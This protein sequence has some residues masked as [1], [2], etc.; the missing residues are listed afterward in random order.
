MCCARSAVASPT[1]DSSS[2]RLNYYKDII[3]FTLLGTLCGGAPSHIMHLP[4]SRV[5]VTKMAAAQSKSVEDSGPGEEYEE[6]VVLHTESPGEV[7]VRRRTEAWAH[8]EQELRNLP[9]RLSIGQLHSLPGPGDRLL[10]RY[11]GFLCRAE[12]LLLESDQ[13]LLVKLLDHGVIKKVAQHQLGPLKE[14]RVRL[15][16]PFSFPV[17]LAGVE[18]A[19]TSGSW[20]CAA[21][22]CLR[23]LFSNNIVEMEL[24]GREVDLWVGEMSKDDPLG[25]DEMIWTSAAKHVM[26]LGV[27]LPLGTRQELKELFSSDAW[28]LDDKEHDTDNEN[29]MATDRKHEIKQDPK[30][31][32]V[33]ARSLVQVA[34]MI[35]ACGN[36]KLVD[37]DQKGDGKSEDNVFLKDTNEKNVSTEGVLTVKCSSCR[38]LPLGPVFQC[39]SGHLLC[40]ACLPSLER[41]PVQCAGLASLI[42]PAGTPWPSR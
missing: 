1:S 6:V 35:D 25:P 27:A 31:E 18:P 32:D 38:K 9:E 39:H 11:G 23:E 24:G 16:E 33:K 14:A 42:L 20:T 10:C 3:L 28:P 26:D 13:Y 40:E 5:C 21:R 2:P 30:A 36:M 29:N 17:S 22:D 41:C 34:E 7:W 12:V 8:F 37:S 19:G 15:A 4:E